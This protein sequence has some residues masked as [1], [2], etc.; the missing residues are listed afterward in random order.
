M[1]HWGPNHSGDCGYTESG[2]CCCWYDTGIRS[3][4]D[5][6]LQTERPH[7]SNHDFSLTTNATNGPKY[8]NNIGKSMNGNSSVLKWR[9]HPVTPGGT[10]DSGGIHLMMW[11]DI[12]PVGTDGKPKNGWKLVYN[13]IDT[14]Q[15]LGDYTSPSEHD[16]EVRN[17]GTNSR[18]AFG[19][20]LH[21]RK[22]QAGDT[23]QWGTGG[24]VT[25]PPP[26]QPPPTQPPPSGTAFKIISWGDNDTTQDAEEDWI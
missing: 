23:L 10:A 22:L 6:Q 19:G 17:S 25:Q 20:G 14:G 24:G 3:N 7:P 11:A 21:W 26:T 13:F 18:T 5:V 1:K 15:V 12:D 4:G 2:D 16:C 9:V 8:M